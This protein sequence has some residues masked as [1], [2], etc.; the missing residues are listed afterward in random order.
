MTE[1]SRGILGKYI[2]GRY[3]EVSFAVMFVVLALCEKTQKGSNLRK[4]V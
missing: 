2:L 4:I 1:N 3:E